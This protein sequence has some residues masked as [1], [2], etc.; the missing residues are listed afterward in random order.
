MMAVAMAKPQALNVLWAVFGGR[1]GGVTRQR[2][3]HAAMLRWELSGVG[4]LCPLTRMI[5]FLR[6]KRAQA[7]LILEMLNRSWPR[8]ANGRGIEWNPEVSAEW[9]KAKREMGE[10]N[11]RGMAVLDE[12]IALRVGAQ[13]M[14]PESDLFGERWETFSGIL[15]RSGSMRRGA[16]YAHPIS[17]PR[18]SDGVLSSSPGLPTPR[19]RDWKRGGKD[20]LEEALRPSPSASAGVPTPRATDGTKGG[21]N[22]RGSS[23]DLM[24]PSAAV[25]LL[26]TPRAS[27]RENRQTKRSP[28]QEA[29]EHGLCLAAEACMLLP[30]PTKS[31]ANGAGSHGTGGADLRTTISALTSTGDRTPS[32]SDAGSG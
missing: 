22:Q 7:E 9:A 10:L 25:T 20:G 27:A 3:G 29:G 23:G 32:P 31:D 2:T 14:I 26:P 19:A 17:E 28:S 15:P 16:L 18:T 13:W 5:P 12:A 6:V 21:P 1:L 8:S 4:M 24:L 11:K 30:T